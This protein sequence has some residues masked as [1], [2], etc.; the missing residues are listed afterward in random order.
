[1]AKPL[2]T[3]C[4]KQNLSAASSDTLATGEAAL[5]AGSALAK[6]SSAGAGLTSALT[7]RAGSA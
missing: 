2:L 1:M 7:S 3:L 6:A 4:F 5:A